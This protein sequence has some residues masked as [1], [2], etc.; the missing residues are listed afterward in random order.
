MLLDV[1]SEGTGALLTAL[2]VI[3]R[4][5]EVAHPVGDS[6]PASMGIWVALVRQV[7]LSVSKMVS[8]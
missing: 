5:R 4:K 8:L 7:S 1:P 3:D 2:E 6:E